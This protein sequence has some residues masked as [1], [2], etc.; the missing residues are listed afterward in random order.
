[1]SDTIT[2]YYMPN[3]QTISNQGKRTL[4]SISADGVF[5]LGDGVSH[6]EAATAFNEQCNAKY[7][8]AIRERDGAL[9]KLATMTMA[10]EAKHER[11][12]EREREIIEARAELK[13][14]A[15]ISHYDGRDISSW[16]REAKDLRRAIEAH[17]SGLCAADKAGYSIPL[18]PAAKGEGK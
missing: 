17:N 13:R 10:C 18:P 16:M 11:M 2:T 5:S 9:S 3:G 15:P 14:H 6:S 8:A 4:F 7:Q 12:M 1:M